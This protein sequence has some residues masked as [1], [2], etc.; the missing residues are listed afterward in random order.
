MEF[1]SIEVHNLPETRT[2]GVCLVWVFFPFFF[3]GFLNVKVVY[4]TKVPR[5]SDEN[6]T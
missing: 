3:V 2:E 6:L 4:K 5:A 1:L